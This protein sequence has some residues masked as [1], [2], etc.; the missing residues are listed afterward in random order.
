MVDGELNML[1]CN[2]MK[3]MFALFIFVIIIDLNKCCIN[4]AYCISFQTSQDQSMD[5]VIMS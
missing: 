4:I 2:M 3:K 5:Y 1:L